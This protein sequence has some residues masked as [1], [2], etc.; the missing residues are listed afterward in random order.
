[1]IW[2]TVRSW[3]YFCC[4]CRASPSL[5]AKNIINLI[6]VLTIWWCPCAVFSCVVGRGCLLLIPSSALLIS[7]CSV[8]YGT[9][10]LFP[11]VLVCTR[12][13]S[14]P[15]VESW[16]PPV[17]WKPCNQIPQVFKVRSLGDSWSLCW[18]SRLGSLMWG[19]LLLWCFSPVCG[20]PTWRVWVF[21]FS[22]FVPLLPSHCSFS[23]VFGCGVSFFFFFGGFQCP[24]VNGCLR[25]SWNFGFMFSLMRY[26]FR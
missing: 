25:T 24:P 17:L 1:M 11:W 2:A 14:P 21:I 9:T 26:L 19:I 12:F 6:L 5:A 16:F 22:W 4:L 8:S 23:F 10:T 20:L 15:R 3:S 13:C 18:I 7:V